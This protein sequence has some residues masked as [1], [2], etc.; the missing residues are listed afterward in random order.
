MLRP[1]SITPL[2]CRSFPSTGNQRKIVDGIAL[3]R[4]AVD[5]GEPML[6]RRRERNIGIET[7]ELAQLRQM[8]PQFVDHRREVAVKQQ[9]IAI[10]PSRMN[11]FSAASLRGLIGHQTAPVREM[12]KTQAKA[13]GS[14]PDRI[15]TFSRGRHRNWQARVRSIAETLHVSVAQVLSVHGQAWR[16]SI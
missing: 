5:I 10:E 3:K 14:L 1:E 16:V 8:R 7:D 15:A 11:W 4:L 9:Q 13:I 6:E 12:P 2:V